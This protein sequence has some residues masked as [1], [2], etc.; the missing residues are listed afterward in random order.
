MLP[1]AYTR[2]RNFIQPP[3]ILWSPDVIS[4][5]PIGLK[6]TMPHPIHHAGYGLR[7]TLLLR[8]PVNGSSLGTLS[9]YRWHYGTHK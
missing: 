9:F 5:A 6:V 7:R 8:R 1:A 2:Y 3:R 4:C